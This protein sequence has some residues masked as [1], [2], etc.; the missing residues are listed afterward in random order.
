M[1]LGFGFG[2]HAIRAQRVTTAPRWTIYVLQSHFLSMIGYVWIISTTCRFT[3]PACD[4][5]APYEMPCSQAIIVVVM[6]HRDHILITNELS[7]HCSVYHVLMDLIGRNHERNQY[8]Q[9]EL[10]VEAESLL[11]NISS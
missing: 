10:L 9:S 7:T 8:E 1:Y 2:D 5:D 6:G 3:L 11:A 4:A